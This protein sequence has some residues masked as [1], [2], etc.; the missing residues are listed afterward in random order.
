MEIV[1]LNEINLGLITIST[2]L[3][4]YDYVCVPVIVSLDTVSV[5]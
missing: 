3:P 5:I 2:T 4:Y 1:V